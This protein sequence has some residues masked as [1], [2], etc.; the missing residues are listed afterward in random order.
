MLK[1][2]TNM[3]SLWERIRKMRAV[4]ILAEKA[5]R[6]KD[7]KIKKSILGYDPKVWLETDVQ[8]RDTGQ[9]NQA[10][11]RIALPPPVKG[12]HKYSHCSHKYSHCS[13]RE[14][15]PT[16]QDNTIGCTTWI[17]LFILFDTI[18]ARSAAGDHV[19][20]P[21]AA[22][23]AEKK[24]K[25]HGGKAR[26]TRTEDATLK[27]TLEEELAKFKA[28]VRHIARHEADHQQGDWFKAAGRSK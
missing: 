14:W 11:S 5:E 21:E 19:K 24:T 27:P 18:A 4:I 13:N 22:A 20:D 2:I 10:Y 16:Q 26:R 12:K 3:K 9:L 23:R 8:I 7:E 17:E 1:D 6:G 28:I 25:T 15:P